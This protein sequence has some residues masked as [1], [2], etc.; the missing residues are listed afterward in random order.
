VLLCSSETQMGSVVGFG[1]EAPWPVK[2]TLDIDDNIHTSSSF[3]REELEIVKEKACVVCRRC[4]PE[5]EVSH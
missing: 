2:V 4:L 1:D 3:P 5:E